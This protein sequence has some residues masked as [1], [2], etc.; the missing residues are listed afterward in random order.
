MNVQEERDFARFEFKM[1]F[2][3]GGGG[4][5]GVDIPYCNNPIRVPYKG[6]YSNS[7]AIWALLCT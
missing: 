4:G 5:G 1:S 6:T 2:G 3:G 7:S